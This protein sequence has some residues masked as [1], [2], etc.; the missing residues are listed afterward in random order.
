MPPFFLSC[1]A[2]LL[3]APLATLAQTADPLPA[4]RFYGGLAVYASAAQRLGGY[5]GSRYSVPV[6][7]TLG[8]Q[9]RPRLAVQVGLAYSR[10]RSNYSYA[11][12]YV[13][14]NANL[15]SNL[16]TSDYARRTFSTSVLARYTITRPGAHR[17]QVDAL[18]GPSLEHSFSSS[19]TTETTT[20]QG[21][22]SVSSSDYSYANNNLRLNVGPSF[23]YRFGK[24][25]DAM[26][27]I[28]LNI[29]LTNSA[30]TNTAMAL[31]LRYRF[32][33]S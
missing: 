31:G 26:Y 2:L 11:N 19:A 24:H 6:Q 18:G 23:R 32:G 13:D 20:S 27:D 3:S 1:A 25:L 28:L 29:S 5:Y 16:T 22:T 12:E 14:P 4:H 21:S 8:Y 9:L 15:I 17:F 7:A 10:V 30:Y 33:P